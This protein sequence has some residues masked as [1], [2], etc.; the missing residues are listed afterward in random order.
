M[1]TKASFLPLTELEITPPLAFNL[2]ETRE[3]PMY[4]PV[5]LLIIAVP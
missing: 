5:I 3:F 1:P 2:S 4:F